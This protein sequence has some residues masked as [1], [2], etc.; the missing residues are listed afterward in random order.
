[1]SRGALALAA[2]CLVAGCG[3]KAAAPTPAGGVEYGLYRATLV[4]PGG[5]LPFGLELAREG[6]ADV[7]YLING[8]ERV[9]V[10][11]VT[12]AGD[13]VTLLMPGYANKLVARAVDG[14]L[15]GEAV[16]LRPKGA[17]R[18]WRFVAERGKAYRFFPAP[19]GQ[20]A[21]FAGRWSLTFTADDGTTD[22]KIAEFAQDGHVVAGSVMAPDGDDRYIA[23]EARGN[24]LFLSRFD[25]GS[26]Q[27][28]LARLDANGELAGEFWSGGG[29]HRRFAG[30]RDAN[31]TLDLTGRQSVLKAGVDRLEFTFP[32]LDG[33]PVSTGDARF[34][35]KVLIVSIGGSWCPNCHDETAFL[36]Q[37]LAQ[38]RARGLEA[39]GVMFEYVPTYAE[40][41]PL[42]RRF[43]ERHRVDYPLLVAGSYDKAEIASKLPVLEK[44]YA[45][46]TT[47]LV[48]RK[49]RIRHVHTGFSGPATG[50]HHEDLKREFTAQVDELLSEM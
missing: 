45:Y 10:D 16:L 21:E 50:Q 18:T 27:L 6:E 8:P 30:K 49:G 35:G 24:A 37:L 13:S 42:V 4:V 15:E 39:V 29:A 1:M 44:L 28:Y 22:Q 12:I 25:G 20:Q 38:R 43:A 3:D 14:R 2:A 34:R 17:I 9:R 26:A 41:V 33:R 36:V 7:A 40:A 11:E 32:D 19:G 46:P 23:G 5:D 31:A 48:D 47:F